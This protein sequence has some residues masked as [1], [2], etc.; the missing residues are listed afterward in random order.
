MPAPLHDE[1]IRPDV[2]PKRQCERWEVARIA[3]TLIGVRRALSYLSLG[4][5]DSVG[6]VTCAGTRARMCPWEHPHQTSRT[7]SLP[8]AGNGKPS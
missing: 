6:I 7:L 5:G 1:Q 3:D 2:L 8:H 4:G